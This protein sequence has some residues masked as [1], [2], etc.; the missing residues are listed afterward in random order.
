M[1]GGDSTLRRTYLVVLLILG[2]QLACRSDNNPTEDFEKALAYEKSYQFSRAYDIYKN[3]VKKYGH[4]EGLQAVYRL[5]FINKN[6]LVELEDA[7]VKSKIKDSEYYLVL[8]KALLSEKELNGALLMLEKANSLEPNNPEI[9][10]RLGAT[11]NSIGDDLLHMLYNEDKAAIE[12][13]QAIKRKGF[14]IFN[15]IIN[16]YPQ[17][18]LGCEAQFMLGVYYGDLCTVWDNDYEKAIFEY[19]KVLKN[20][21]KSKEA[22]LSQGAI[23]KLKRLKKGRK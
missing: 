4:E 2:G 6:R 14:V 7:K 3:I 15:K 9:L 1:E 16:E 13:A 17:S 23:D 8:G 11:Y 21:P 19:K 22:V 20:Y 12:K 10:L 18:E 5:E